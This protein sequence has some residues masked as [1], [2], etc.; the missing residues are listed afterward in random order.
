MPRRLLLLLLAALAVA[1]RLSAQDR[2]PPVYVTLWFDTEDYIL[3]QDDDATRR[4]AEML[5][6]LGVRATFKVVGEKARVLEQRGRRDVIAALGRHDIGYHSNT[7]S[8]Q[9]TPAV[10]LQ[11]AGWDEGRAEFRRRELAGVQDLTRIFGVT[12]V[13]YGQPG[14]AWAPQTYPALRDL[15]IFMY[16]DEADHVGIDDQPFYYGGMLN[17]F[18]MRSNL[19][20][21]DLSGGT[22]LE[23]GKAAFTGIATRLRAQGGGTISIYYHPNEWVQTEFWDGV[24]FR[25]GANP[26]REE[27]KLP[28]TRPAAET[29]QAFR[30]FEQYVGFIKSQP[31]VRFVTAT[32]LKTI[33][34]DQALSRSF[35][36][37]DL[38]QAARAMQQEITFQRFDGYALSAADVFGLLTEAAAGFS[39]RGAWPAAV[40]VMPLDGPGRPYLPAIG[41]TRASSFRWSAFAQAV[42]DTADYCRTAHRMPAEVWVGSQS[43]SPAEYLAT[44][45][46]AV[47]D[48]IDSGPPPAD[49]RRLDGRLTADRYV[50]QDSAGLWSWPIFPEGFHAP[51]LMELARLQAWTLKPAVAH[52]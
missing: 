23:T 36:R 24:N 37:D 15:G 7:H 49:V 44:L 2:T 21:M 27:W 18:R 48:A 40:K 17:V 39:E 52:R 28:G 20:R 46:G 10:Y 47:A 22:S 13:A 5:T 11:N 32:E 1:P 6:R 9:P 35:G 31:G 51:R 42:R 29:E 43:L 16:L 12:P 19:A 25:N 38:R 33:Y 26:P 50:A 30:D 34:Q 4:L 3:P 14:S 8:Q 45:A 41:G